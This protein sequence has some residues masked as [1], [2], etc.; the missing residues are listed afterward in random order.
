MLN[1]NTSNLLSKPGFTLAESLIASVVLAIGVAAIAG[2]LAASSQQS[3]ALDNGYDAYSAA[4]VL[5]EEIAALPVTLPAGPKDTQG[6]PFENMDKS[7]YDTVDDFDGYS[8]T[9]PQPTTENAALPKYQ[10]TVSI[11]F[12]NSPTGPAVASGDFALITVE[13]ASAQTKHRARI[14]RIVT[15]VK[16][17]R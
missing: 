10:R 14:Q 17:D 7:T 11:E 9:Y 12:R 8:D 1:T 2:V 16:L 5:M 13:A 15:S 4:R 6:A 3:K